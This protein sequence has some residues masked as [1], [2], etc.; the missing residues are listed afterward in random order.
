MNNKALLDEFSYQV[1]HL[2]ELEYGDFKRK[3]GQYIASFER[4][5]NNPDKS[6]KKF[7]SDLRYQV[8]YNPNGNIE[9]TRVKIEELIQETMSV[10]KRL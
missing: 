9:T 5:I 8:I 10:L 1:N 2:Y 3:V 7:I 4:Q 6:L